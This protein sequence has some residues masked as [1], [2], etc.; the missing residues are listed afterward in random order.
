M[1]IKQLEIEFRLMIAYKN[2]QSVAASLSLPLLR[3][4]LCGH[5]SVAL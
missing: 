2:A 1:P 3:N 5:H 4:R